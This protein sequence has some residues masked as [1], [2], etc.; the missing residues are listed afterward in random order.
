[1]FE[2]GV[3]L[4]HYLP[5]SSPVH[6]LDP[7]TKLLLLVFWGIAVFFLDMPKDYACILLAIWVIF[8]ISRIPVRHVLAGL[9][10]VLVLLAVTL[11]LN[12]FFVKGETL[13]TFGPL[14]ITREG[15]LQSIV[16]GGRMLVLV[17]MSIVLTSTTSAL[18]ITDG[19]ESLLSPL[20]K[21][22]F[23][24]S[25]FALMMTIALR[26]IPTFF[27]EFQRIV[28]AQKSRGAR[29]DDHNFVKRINLLLSVC[30][31]LFNSSFK[32]AHDLGVAMDARGFIPG[33]KRS[34][35]RIL[36]FGVRDILAFIISIAIFFAIR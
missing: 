10:S 12:I 18:E 29:F 1:M 19:F 17:F 11:L 23:P 4:G 6:K 2:Y 8:L 9:R 22:R 27:D 35:Y 21:L 7:R 13:L 15:V 5:L 32:K 30:I 28:N 25:E 33:V 16:M 36:C 31:P 3:F 26:F 20:V 14:T 24:V 34:K